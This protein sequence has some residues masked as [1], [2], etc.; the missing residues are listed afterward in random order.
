MNL[1]VFA[2]IS[3]GD[4]RSMSLSPPLRE[5]ISDVFA[6]LY[7]MLEEEKDAGRVGP[8][9]EWVMTPIGIVRTL[10]SLWPGNIRELK[11][12]VRRA[13]ARWE[14]TDPQDDL[15]PFVYSLHEEPVALF[16]DPEAFVDLWKALLAKVRCARNWRDFF[17]PSKLDMSIQTLTS[18]AS[19]WGFLGGSAGSLDPDNVFAEFVQDTRFSLPEVVVLVCLIVDHYWDSGHIHAGIREEDFVYPD[20]VWYRLLLVNSKRDVFF[21]L[22][23][24]VAARYNDDGSLKPLQEDL[25]PTLTRFTENDLLHE[26]YCQLGA[27]EDW[28]QKAMAA[29]AGIT[30][31][32]ISTRL[33]KYDL[34]K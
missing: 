4:S 19:S 22:P 27:Q 26:Y 5:R 25:V 34:K 21:R 1:R 12:A 33:R 2:R 28:V 31:N 20:D 6:I 23:D 10:Y 8:G 17:L 14:S 11:N 9:A 15:I 13:I 30:P 32:S 29:A 18:V 7:G 16:R 24:H 3:S